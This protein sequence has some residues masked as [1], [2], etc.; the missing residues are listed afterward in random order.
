MTG[1][2]N[3]TP[4]TRETSPS[5]FFNYP[6]LLP[7][8]NTTGTVT[9]AGTPI[10]N[11][12]L[13]AT[14]NLDDTDG[15]A[16]QISYAWNRNGQPIPGATDWYYALT[17][18]DVGLLIT[19][20]ASYVD[21][22][23]IPESATS[24]ATIPVAPAGDFAV[25]HF[26][27]DLHFGGESAFCSNC[28]QAPTLSL[29]I[30]G[31]LPGTGHDQLNIMGHLTA[32][33]TFKIAVVDNFSP[34]AGQSFNLLNFNS[35]SGEFTIVFTGHS[36]TTGLEWNTDQLYNNGTVSVI[37]SGNPPTNIAL[38]NT[39]TSLP[40]N[41]TVTNPI[42]MGDI[43]IT[44]ADGGT[45]AVILVGNDRDFFE[46]TSGKLWLKAEVTLDHETKPGYTVTLTTADLSVIH[47][48]TI[49]NVDEAAVITGIFERAV[50]EGD[51]GDSA[52]ATGNVAISDVDANDNPIFDNVTDTAG[53]NGYGTFALTDGTWLYT[54]NQ[55]AV[56]TLGAGDKVTD[57]ITFTATDNS[58]QVVIVTINGTND[59]SLITGTFTGTVT[60]GTLSDVATATGDLA[61]TDVDAID[62]PSFDNVT[63]TAGDNGY[64]TFAL[65]DG[66]WLY[67]LNQSAVQ[68]L[69]AGDTVSDTTT[70]TATDGSTQ[71]VTITVNHPPAA[72]FTKTVSGEHPPVEVSVDASASSDND[73]T[74]V[75][76]SWDWGDNTPASTAATASHTYTTEGTYTITLTVTD[77]D[78]AIGTATDTVAVVDSL[79]PVITLVGANP[80]ILDV[81]TNSVGS[82]YVELGAQANDAYD[83]DIS[84]NLVI[85]A[86]AVNMD[87]VGDY[88]VTYNASDAAGNAA[89]QQVRTVTVQDSTAPVISLTGPAT[90]SLDYNAT[91]HEL[92]ATVTDNYDATLNA[93]VGGDTVDTSTL[94]EFTVT[95]NATDAAGNPA[96]EVQRVVTVEDK[97]APIIVLVGANPQILDV[98]TNSVGSSYVELGAQA[99]DAYDG[100]ISNNLVIDASAVNMDV[101]GDYFVTYNVSDA[102]GNA[103]EQQ[104]R[105]VTVQDST[106]P[107]ISLIGPATVSLDY[108]AT[109][110]ELGATVTDNYDATLNATVGG[111]TVDT[112]TLGEFTVTYNATDA[113]GNPALEVQRVVTVEDKTAPVI[114]LVG[115]NPQILDVNTN[116]V[117]SSYVELGAQAN[118][119]YDGDISNNLVIDASTVNMD[120]VGDY[121]VTYNAYDAAANPAA[122][123]TRVVTVADLTAPEITLTG[124][125]E[126]TLDYGATY[127]EL[128]STVTDNYDTN[129]NI[130]VGGDTVNTSILGTYTV[131]Y[132]ATDAAGNSAAQATRVVTVADLTAPVITLIGA[133]PQILDVNTNDAGSSYVE[134][135]VQTYDAYDGDISNNLVIDA[136]TVNMDVVGDYLVTYNVYDAAANPAAQVTRVVTVADLTAPVISLIGHADVTLD[137]GATYQ[138]LGA[139]VTD[140]Y[141]T[142]VN[143]A[144]GGDTVNTSTL[145]TYTVTYNATDAAG[146]P[147]LEVQRVITVKDKTAPV[148]VLVGA[149]PQILDV[150]TNSVG[151]SYVELGAQADDA[152]DGDI[153][154]N[155]V[156]DASAVNMDVVGDYFVTY[157]VSDAAGNAAEQQVRTA[158]VQDS[159]APVISLIGPATVSLD[160]NATY[161]ELGATVTDN[162]DATLNATVGGDTVDTSTL[163]EFT[164]T[165]NATDAAGNPALEVHRVVTVEDKTA[166]IIVLVGPNPQILDV[167]TNSVGSSYV[168]LEA[169]AD[170][171]YDG[172]ISNNLVIDASAVN[173]DVVGDY[174]V[175]YNVSD[176]AGNAAE[177]QVRTVTVQDSTAPVISLTG[178]NPLLFE[179]S[180]TAEYTD[181][182]ATCEDTVDGL[183][184]NAIEVSGDLVDLRTPGTYTIRYNC[185]DLSENQAQEQTRTVTV[186][187][188]LRPVITGVPEDITVEADDI[189]EPAIVTATDNVSDIIE[190]VYQQTQTAADPPAD[191]QLVRTWTATD[192]AGNTATATQRVTVLQS[193]PSIAG[194]YNASGTVDQA[195]YALWRSTFGSTTELG[196]DGNGNGVVDAADYT[197]YRDNL[198]NTAAVAV[199]A[200]SGLPT[201]D[202][203][204]D[205]AS[206]NVAQPTTEQLQ[207]EQEASTDAETIIPANLTTTTAIATV[208]SPVVPVDS[209][210]NNT[211]SQTPGKQFQATA[212]PLGHALR[213]TEPVQKFRYLNWQTSPPD[214]VAKSFVSLRP[215]RAEL[216]PA[217][218]NDL[219]RGLL[220][221]PRLARESHRPANSP[222]RATARLAHNRHDVLPGRSALSPEWH[223]LGSR[224]WSSGA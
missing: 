106:A 121:L 80:Q 112:S 60:K 191:Y 189:P 223:Q 143:V 76:Y 36:L 137:Y 213:L 21:G 4:V 173:M 18:A 201:Q 102:A 195:D 192:Q 199:A 145:G 95:Y 61:I 158:T 187:D 114:V 184:S 141:D 82:S 12:V 215:G 2:L 56:Q 69:N 41:S 46:V 212:K 100:D 135:G 182:G 20:V 194:D 27:S 77:D 38:V 26:G 222:F 185:Q 175:T 153:S 108:N 9:I 6:A 159:T 35:I 142:N 81:S 98:N 133:T 164:V 30:G 165:Y 47:N 31:L 32:G 200:G 208:V 8:L 44:D 96:L 113:A 129:V 155:L 120:V 136:S 73:G 23:G 116:S 101:V 115:A 124:H 160:Y 28:E 64:G 181:P 163:G 55:S 217:L 170:D 193:T 183:L 59:A 156:I 33:G 224:L 71:V 172:D 51:I 63:D 79:P 176:A 177:Q 53:D 14:N 151:S 214:A 11:S 148:I 91:Y 202:D 103:A 188:T 105:T 13:I 219:G 146:N 125:A 206:A 130:A 29:K 50:D 88:L 179:A 161:H 10:E 57:Q 54:L 72:S 45:N 144:V 209:A 83:G 66:T 90:V 203:P 154:N 221:I 218:K 104:V 117:G 220:A 139:T 211:V 216:P 74:I 128:G 22:S 149:N 85:D 87:V 40:E 207:P 34:V 89:E 198:G 37:D 19:V 92:G 131:T 118:D 42:K 134:L 168:E 174:F 24:A 3:I 205:P 70:F 122:Q 171:A 62:S 169:Q 110:H 58:P 7:A 15:I 162:Y 150:N 78:D 157:N 127:Q 107:V 1:T 94:G 99:N 49:T 167:N 126:V 147:A 93:T 190:L 86:S 5:F 152:Y 178:D 84:N 196:A 166:P 67:T 109:Y 123:A 138:E 39:T 17:Q 111:D 119:A 97:T 132:N 180:R 186:Q 140:N 43:V 48:L 210:V 204:A 25:I 68:T 197:I 65:T 75:A 16:G 52:T